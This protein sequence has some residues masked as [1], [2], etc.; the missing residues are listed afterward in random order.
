MG[1]VSDLINLFQ[2]NN[3]ILMG[4]ID[5]VYDNDI[6]DV[7]IKGFLVRKIPAQIPPGVTRKVKEDATE[8]SS[9]I[10]ESLYSKGQAVSI[11]KPTKSISN[12]IIIGM[13]KASSP[14]SNSF[15]Y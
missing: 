11:L 9:A 15:T 5:Q 1:G 8:S 3:N 2:G 14:S 12:L 13:F 10:Y 7:K 4:I 6:Y